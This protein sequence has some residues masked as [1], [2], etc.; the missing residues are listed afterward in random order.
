MAEVV[1]LVSVD[2]AL[3]CRQP[4]GAAALELYVNQYAPSTLSSPLL[5]GLSME[6]QADFFGSG[7]TAR[8]N[9]TF[10]SPSGAPLYAL[11]TP[12]PTGILM[13]AYQSPSAVL[14]VC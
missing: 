5:G 3:P 2:H 4:K 6:L 7:T 9:L 13:P 1:L 11:P 8:A 12:Y 10:L 14:S